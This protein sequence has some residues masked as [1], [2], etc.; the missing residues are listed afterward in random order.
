MA[1]MMFSICLVSFLDMMK[2]LAIAHINSEN[3]IQ[4]I[5]F[6]V[7]FILWDLVFKRNKK[8]IVVMC[9]VVEKAY[10]SSEL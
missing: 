9:K 7:Y 1:R 5:Y 4:S 6:L 8:K 3:C 10:E 2:K